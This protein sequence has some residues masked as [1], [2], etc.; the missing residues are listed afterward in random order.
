MT[1]DDVFRVV[2]IQLVPVCEGASMLDMERLIMTSCQV[3]VM[4]LRLTRSSGEGVSVLH[5]FFLV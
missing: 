4:V 3:V 1:S 5:R 2:V